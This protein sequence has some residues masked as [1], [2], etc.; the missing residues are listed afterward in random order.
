MASGVGHSSS[1]TSVPVS[2]S[3]RRGQFKTVL[4]IV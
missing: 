2:L 1:A 4:G 3:V